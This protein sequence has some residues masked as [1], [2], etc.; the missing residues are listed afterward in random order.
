[1][2]DGGDGRF[3]KLDCLIYGQRVCI[4]NVYLPNDAVERRDFIESF[5]MRVQSVDTMIIGGDFNFIMNIDLDRQALGQ[6]HTGRRV[7]SYHTTSVKAFEQLILIYKL[8]DV[9]RF[10]APDKKEFTFTSD[11]YNT[12]TRLDRIYVSRI[13]NTCILDVEHVPMIWT[14]HEAVCLKLKLEGRQLGKGYWKC[15]VSTLDDDFFAVDFKEMLESFSMECGGRFTP[16]QLEE[17]KLKVKRLNVIQSQRLASNMRADLEA[18]EHK[19]KSLIDKEEVLKCKDEMKHLLL[20]K[21][22]SLRIRAKA[23]EP[24]N[25]DLPTRYLLKRE[26][27]SADNK[28]IDRTVDNGIEYTRSHD[29]I[30]VVHDYYR[31]LYKS[32]ELHGKKIDDLVKD[33]PRLADVDSSIC[34][35]RISYNECLKARK[36][37]KNEKSP[38]PDGLPAKFYER[39]FSFVW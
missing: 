34:E 12:S 29:I 19:L 10:F 4:V 39:F 33:A 7:K 25:K 6:T 32:Q 37:M 13:N 23:D 8:I 17:F 1:V 38:G 15:N 27:D 5:M 16:E 30:S 2:E 24:T 18:L 21:V 3:L 14:D 31:S 20:Y 35:G 9:F 22:E 26:R 36:T 11:R 28:N